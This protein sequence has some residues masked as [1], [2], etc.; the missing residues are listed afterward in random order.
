MRCLKFLLD[1]TA[2]GLATLIS[3]TKKKFP[4]ANSDVLEG[5]IHVGSE[6]LQ[7][8]GWGSLVNFDTEE[9]EVTDTED[10]QEILKAKIAKLADEWKIIY[11]FKPTGYRNYHDFPS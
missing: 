4:D 5:L 11:D 10:N 2:G 7:L 9:Q 3:E 8:P 6:T 1:S